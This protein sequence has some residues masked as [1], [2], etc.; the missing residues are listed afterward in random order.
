[1]ANGYGGSSGSSSGSRTTSARTTTPSAPT[2]RMAAERPPAPPGFHYMPDGTL[3]S[4]AEHLKLFGQEPEVVVATKIIKSFNLDLSDLPATSTKRAFSIVADNDSEFILEIKDKDTGKY[5]NFFTNAFQTAQYRLEEI[6]TGGRYNGVITFPDITGSTDQYDIYLYAK[7]GTIH[8][9]YIE[10]RFLDNSIDLNSSSG[11]NSLMMQKVIYQYA[12]ITL[13]I[14]KMSPNSTIEM[15]GTGHSPDSVTIARGAS[16]GKI[17][18]IL[19]SLVSTAS[20]AYT[21]IKQPTP[22][23][24]IG[25]KT[26]T[27]GSAP[28]LLPGEDEY[29]TAT[30]AFTGD[31]V[32]GAVTSGSVVRM[33]NTDLSEVIKVGDKITSPVTSGTTNCEDELTVVTLDEDVATIMAVGDAVSGPGCPFCDANPHFDTC[34]V[35]VVGTGGNAKRFTIAGAQTFLNDSTLNFSSKVN[36]S[37]TTV[38]VV[39]TSGAGT[40]FTMSQAI[41][42]RDNQ[43][44]T[45]TPRANFQWPLSDVVKIQ[46]GMTILPSTNVTANTVVSDYE[47]TITIDEGY[48]SEETIVQDRVSAINTLGTPTITN[49]VVSAQTGNVVFNNQQALLLADDSIKIGASGESS[50]A[51]LS[52]YDLRITD[53]SIALT[54]ITTTTTSAVSASATI[55][56]ASVNGILPNTSTIS[57]IGINAAQADPLI[58]ARS[59]TTGAGNLTASVAQTLESGQTFTFSGAGQVATITGNIEILRAGTSSESIFFDIEKLLTIT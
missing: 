45:F 36:R 7:P 26:V 13:T 58:T 41:Q 14:G 5:Y 3:M 50:I 48:D 35:T 25:T 17:P 20:K 2:Q 6:V 33:D 37:H 52:G 46:S 21:I 16:S 22:E 1:M 4:D 19:K 30:A 34:L 31:D 59:A 47:N 39:E 43:P 11:S 56:V 18:F 57:G 29:P 53:L 8:T 55:P 24:I 23:D 42:F 10:Y 9:E 27:V 12:N 54:P 44:L 15:T 38:T 32:N 28:V 40:D 49:G 51:N